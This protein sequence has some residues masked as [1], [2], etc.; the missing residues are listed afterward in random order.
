MAHELNVDALAEAARHVYGSYDPNWK[1]PHER[2]VWCA[3]W[4]FMAK[5]IA[6]EDER[7]QKIVEAI[8]RIARKARP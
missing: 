1:C 5:Q 8:I 2:C 3:E 4:K 6:D 7:E